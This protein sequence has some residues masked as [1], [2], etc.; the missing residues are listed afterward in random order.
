MSAPVWFIVLACVGLPLVILL[1]RGRS[2]SPSGPKVPDDASGDPLVEADF[3]MAYGLYDKAA[4]IINEA[5]V[6]DPNRPEFAGKLLETYFIWGKPDEFLATAKRYERQLRG[7]DEWDKARIMAP[8][9]C[10]D[11]SLFRR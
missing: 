5:L 8:Q 2:D 7:T 6:E 11:E 3:H 10:P 4:D 9:I 1:L